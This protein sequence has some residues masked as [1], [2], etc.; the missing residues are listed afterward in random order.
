MKTHT[1]ALLAGLVVISAMTAVSAASD[2]TLHTAKKPSIQTGIDRLLK[3]YKQELKGKRVGLITNP[4]GVNASLKSSVDVLYEAPDIH[5]TALFGPEHGVRGDAQAGDKVTSYIDEKTGLPVYSLYGET[6]KPTPDM[7]KDT[8]VLIFDIQDVGTR[9]YTYIYT[10]AYAME[11]AKEKGIPFY[12][13]DRPNPQGGRNPDG[14][15]LEPDYA[16]FVGLYPI[17]LKHGMTIGELALLFNKEFHIGA[18]LTVVKMKRWKRTMT[19]EDTGLPFVLPSPNIPTPDS[20]FAYSATGLIEGTN[21]SEGRGTT[22]PFELIGAPYMKSTELEERLNSLKL[23]G[24]TFRAASFIPSFSK[25]QGKLCH[26]V[27]VYVTNRNTFGAAKT[28]LSI[29]KTMHD[30]YPNDFSFLP[31][32]SFDKLIGNGWVRKK[33]EKG[34]SIED[35]TGTYQRR[36]DQFKTLRKQYLIY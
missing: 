12:V 11:A 26:G 6:R 21:V 4:T 27:Q 10:M 2:R 31:T 13:L 14:P 34:A 5:L 36:L 16:S 24:V 22:K 15:V 33:I 30:L 28:G 1:A 9:Y 17:P 18:D 23:P 35:I 8:D 32:G 7:L 20:I 3:D 29:L 19:I 25:H